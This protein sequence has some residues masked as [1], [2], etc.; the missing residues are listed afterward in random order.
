MARFDPYTKEISQESVERLLF[1]CVGD[2]PLDDGDMRRNLTRM[3]N[4]IQVA[5]NVTLSL[6][7]VHAFWSWRS[8]EWD[9]GFL[10]MPVDMLKEAECWFPEYLI[11]LEDEEDPD[12][13]TEPWCD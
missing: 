5:F 13:G 9:A 8:E 4:A 3:R 12:D 10:T 2:G 1:A 11:W 7:E 6:C